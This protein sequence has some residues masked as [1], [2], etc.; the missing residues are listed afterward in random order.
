ML[1][2]SNQLIFQCLVCKKNYKKGYK[3]LIKRFV[4]TYEFCNEH[5]NKSILLLRKGVCLY[6]YVDSWG[7]FNE[8]SLPDKNAFYSELNSEVPLIKTVQLEKFE[9]LKLRK[10]RDY[11][12]L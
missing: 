11:Q 9:Q 7:R 2:K 1:I 6:E 10:L 4:D 5:I 8:I 3:Q 12:D